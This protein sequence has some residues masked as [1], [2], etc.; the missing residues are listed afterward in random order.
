MYFGDG[1]MDEL[2]ELAGNKYILLHDWEGNMGR[3]YI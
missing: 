3:Y 2:L 1:G